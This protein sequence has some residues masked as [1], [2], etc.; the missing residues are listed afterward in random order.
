MNKPCLTTI[1]SFNEVIYN[2]NIR[3]QTTTNPKD[4]LLNN[5]TYPTTYQYRTCKKHMFEA[6]TSLLHRNPT[7]SP[8]PRSLAHHHLHGRVENTYESSPLCLLARDG[9]WR[10]PRLSQ[11]H[12]WHRPPPYFRRGGRRRGKRS[13]QREEKHDGRW[14]E[15]EA[16]REEEARRRNRAVTPRGAEREKEDYGLERTIW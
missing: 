9:E 13:G 4:I 16:H 10:P 3:C 6:D 8:A 12:C 14:R 15:E 2:I 7:G 1:F 5:S 11:R